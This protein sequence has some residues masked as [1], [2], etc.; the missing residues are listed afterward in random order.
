MQ[1]R[2]ADASPFPLT[3]Y[4]IYSERIYVNKLICMLCYV[5]IYVTFFSYFYSEDILEKFDRLILKNTPYIYIV[6]IKK[7]Y[8]CVYVCM[9]L[10]KD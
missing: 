1:S 2:E 10:Y 9:Y 5:C 3:C 7:I 8:V 4:L 6:P